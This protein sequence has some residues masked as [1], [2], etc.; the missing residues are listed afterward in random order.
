MALGA[1]ESAILKTVLRHGIGLAPT[2][3]AVGVCLAAALNRVLASLLTEVQ[4]FEFAA[5]GI[6]AATLLAVAFAACYLPAR[7][8]ARMNPLTALHCD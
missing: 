5:M 1:D 2:G 8:A 4:P 7:R 3:L 6:T